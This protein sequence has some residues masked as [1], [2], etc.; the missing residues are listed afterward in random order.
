V[1]WRAVA[2][3]FESGAVAGSGAL[4]GLSVAS[5]GVD[6]PDSDVTAGPVVA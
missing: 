5:D 2:A 6:V 3:G 1:V 4:H